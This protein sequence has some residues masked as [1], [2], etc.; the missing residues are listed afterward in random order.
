MRLVKDDKVIGGGLGVFKAV[1]HA[2]RHQGVH[3]DDDPIA[4]GTAEGISGSR[5]LAPDNAERQAEQFSHLLFPVAQETGGRNDEYA[6]DESAGQHL[7]DVESCHD[8]FTGARV[9]RQ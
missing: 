3:A 4:L 8:G 6:A 2:L 9:V 7:A 1:E 5:I